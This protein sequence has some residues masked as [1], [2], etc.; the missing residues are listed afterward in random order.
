[1]EILTKENIRLAEFA[2]HLYEIIGD[3]GNCKKDFTHTR[4][5]LKN[6]RGI[7]VEGTI[8]YFKQN[9]AYCDCEVIFNILL[10]L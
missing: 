8:K 10:P 9:R 3:P 5:I 1:M 2:Q 4:Q 7:D 6:M